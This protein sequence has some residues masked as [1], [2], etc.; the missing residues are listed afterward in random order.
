MVKSERE[1]ERKA[2]SLVVSFSL[3]YRKNHTARSAFSGANRIYS[4]TY[5]KDC[6]LEATQ[7]NVYPHISYPPLLSTRE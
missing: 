2:W 3:L 1:R 5:M 7:C 6:I 4:H